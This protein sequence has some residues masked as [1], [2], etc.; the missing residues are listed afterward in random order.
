M[1]LKPKDV[2]A[3][4]GVSVGIASVKMM[5]MN[6]IPISKHPDGPKARY[7]VTESELERWL[8]EHA[9]PPQMAVT[10][11]KKSKMVYD[12]RFFDENGRIRRAKR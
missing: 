1:L 8:R 4:L 5:E 3:R 11:P 6:R 12:P 10:A 2:A 7:A 9:V